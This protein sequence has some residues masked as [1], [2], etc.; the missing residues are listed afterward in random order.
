MRPIPHRSR[1]FFAGVATLMLAIPAGSAFATTDASPTPSPAP[2]VSAAPAPAPAAQIT[3]EE[4]VLNQA[5]VSYVRLGVYDK[6]CL[7]S[8][9]GQRDLMDP[10]SAN[11]FGNM[12]VIKDRLR[13]VLKVR[14]PDSDIEESLYETQKKIEG[15]TYNI[16]RGSCSSAL[17]KE[18]APAEQYFTLNSPEIISQKIDEAVVRSGGKVTTK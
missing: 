11:Y 5:F 16:L 17:A 3:V 1:L 18:I 12:K 6:I 2:S 4:R 14:S 8:R 9:I 7:A 13:A 15:D 10:L